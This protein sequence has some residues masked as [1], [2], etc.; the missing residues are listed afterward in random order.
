MEGV[1]RLGWCAV[2]CAD[3]LRLAA[4]WSEVL[5]MEIDESYLGDP[6]HYVGLIPATPS[7]LVITFNRVPEPKTVKNRLHFD[8]EVDDVETATARVLE[9]GGHQAR[10]DDFDEYG[11]RWRVMSDPEDNEF[12]LIF[13]TA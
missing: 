8:I 2:D 4:F 7:G 11:F 1:G 12:C 3:P 10:S 13:G 6:P 9:L 5:G